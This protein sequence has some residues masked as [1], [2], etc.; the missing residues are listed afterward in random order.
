VPGLNA[1]GQK[2]TFPSNYVGSDHRTPNKID[3]L[4]PGGTDMTEK[5]LYLFMLHSGRVCRDSACCMYIIPCNNCFLNPGLLV[6][7]AWMTSGAFV[8]GR[9]YN[10]KIPRRV[11][12]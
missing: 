10:S 3:G 6:S 4:S 5:Y 9:S 1:K 2:G 11:L 7:L 8:I 12:L